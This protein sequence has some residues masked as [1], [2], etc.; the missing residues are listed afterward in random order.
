MKAEIFDDLVSGFHEG[1]AIARVE[2]KASG[3]F[4]IGAANLRG[5]GN[6]RASLNPSSRDSLASA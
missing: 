6:V 3:R 2:K 1:G 5:D 4:V